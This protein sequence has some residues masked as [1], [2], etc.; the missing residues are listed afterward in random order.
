MI[1]YGKIPTRFRENS[2]LKRAWAYPLIK[3]LPLDVVFYFHVDNMAECKNLVAEK[4]AMTWLR[5]CTQKNWHTHSYIYKFDC[6]RTSMWIV[7]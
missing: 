6:G 2:Q 5:M 1:T 7:K 4:V 3:S